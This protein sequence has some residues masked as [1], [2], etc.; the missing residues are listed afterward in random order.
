MYT[1]TK[2]SRQR[3]G[4]SSVVLAVTAAVATGCADT[5]SAVDSGANEFPS[6]KFTIVVPYS[7]GGP[8]DLTMR[9]L[10][11]YLERETGETVVVEN[12]DGASGAVAM[13]Y[14]MSQPADGYTLFNMGQGANIITPLLE[15]VDYDKDS[16]EPVANVAAF[17]SALVVGGDSPFKDAE[18]L[19]DEARANPG[20][21][22][23]AT[24]GATTPGQ[25]AV[26]LLNTG[27]DPVPFKPVPFVGNAEAL[28]ALLG[29]N[30]DALQINLT[31][32]VLARAERGDI[33]FLAVGTPERLDY[34]A[35]VP[36]YA[37]LGFEDDIYST[38]PYIVGVKEG[39]DPEI[40]EELAELINGA[41]DDQKF[42]ETIGELFVTDGEDTPEELDAFIDDTYAAYEPIIG[43]GR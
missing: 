20:D 18:A 23:V 7:P 17:P 12:R 40:K 31:D 3:L 21:V 43:G 2:S 10:G 14:A 29:G 30:V 5:G 16:M 8:S 25:M 1:G 39:T 33:R 27:P 22:S 36:T 15:D 35:D 4:F 28:T 19:F 6:D 11:D 37:E 42:V 32:D 26:E 41:V 24:A 13:R 38:S 9:A 34:L